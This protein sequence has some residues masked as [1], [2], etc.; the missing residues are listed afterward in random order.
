MLNF[1]DCLGFC[2]LTEA[3]VDAIV[4]HEHI[5]ELAAA[6]LGN[7][8]LECPDGAA[9]IQRMMQEVIAEAERRGRPQAAL[10]LRA[11]L[12][13]FRAAHPDTCCAAMT[14]TGEHHGP[15]AHP[16]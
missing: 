13:Q 2:G 6:V 11:V 5:P 3:E 1:Q 12:A 10:K 15:E 7:H 14:E 8:L 16:A 4:E 9:R